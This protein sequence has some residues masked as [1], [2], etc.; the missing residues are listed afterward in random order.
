MELSKPN[1]PPQSTSFS[2]DAKV[3]KRKWLSVLTVPEVKDFP[4]KEILYSIS[5]TRRHRTELPTAEESKHRPICLESKEPDLAK[6]TRLASIFKGRVSAIISGRKQSQIEAAFTSSRVSDVERLVSMHKPRPRDKAKRLKNLTR[7]ITKQADDQSGL[8][9]SSKTV[10]SA[11]AFSFAEYL[12]DFGSIS[13]LH[14]TKK[15]REVINL[16][17]L[18]FGRHEDVKS[19][20]FKKEFIRETLRSDW[21]NINNS[22]RK[23]PRAVQMLP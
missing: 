7:S 23:S 16:P 1:K 15:V 22:R 20:C 21:I 17:K 12:D 5:T 18:P 11:L 19:P 14:D 4:L 3:K 9:D 2:L 10:T 13:Q 8:L 6:V